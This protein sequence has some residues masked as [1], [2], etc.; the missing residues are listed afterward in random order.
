M[1]PERRLGSV[2]FTDIVGSTERAAVVGDELWRG[3]LQSHHSL[4]RREIGRF[5]G[6]EVSTTGDGFLAIFETPERA[7]RCACA[8]RDAVRQLGIEIRSGVHTGEV[9]RIERTIGG[10]GVHIGARVAAQAGKG[11]VLVSSTTRDLVAGSGFGFEDRGTHALKGVPGEWR[12]FAVTS[13]PVRLPVASFWQR[14]REAGLPRVVFLYLVAGAAIVWA[15]TLARRALELPGWVLP[16]AVLLLVIGLVVLSATAWV[17]AHPF[18]AAR[19]EREEVPGSWEIDLR[20]V[21]RAVASGRL[22]HLTWARAAL[23]GVFA[24]SLLFGL[25]GLYVLLRDR[26]RSLGPPEAVAG[27]GQALAVLPFRVVGTGM[28]LW[29]EGMVDLL[30]T[31]LDGAGGMRTVSPRTLL[32]RWRSEIPEGTEPSDEQALQVARLAGA[33]Y[34]LLGSMVALGGE[35]RLDAKVFDLRSG[36]LAGE[37]QVKGAPDSVPPLVDRLSLEVLRTALAREPSTGERPDLRRLTT[38]S[39][40]ALKAYL[41]GE[42]AFRRSEWERAIGSLA[43]AVEADSTFALALHRLSLA[44]G[45]ITGFS[46]QAVAY[47]ERAGRLIGRLPER[48]S[49]L[50]QGNAEFLEGDAAALVTLRTLTDR[51][52]DDAEA[53]YMLGDAYFHQGVSRLVPLARAYEAFRRSLE[54]DPRFNP[55]Y[56]HLIWDA[57]ERSDS[58]QARELIERYRA[59]G[60]SSLEARASDLAYRVVWGDAASRENAL[61]E[62]RSLTDDEMLGAMPF[63]SWAPDIAGPALRLYQAAM[64]ARG[65]PAVSDA[66]R[67]D[68]I[69]VMLNGGKVREARELLREALPTR[70]LRGLLGDGRPVERFLILAD[71][72]GY[73]DPGSTARAARALVA[74]PTPQDRFL[75]GTLAAREGRAED[76]RRE[77]DALESLAGEAAAAEKAGPLDP[78]GLAQALRAY[79]ALARGDSAEALRELA[80]AVPRISGVCPGDGCWLH[81]MLRYDLG[82]WLLASGRAQEAIPYLQSVSRFQFLQTRAEL[83]LGRAYEETGEIGEARL[84][85]RRFLRWW[86]ESDPELRPLLDEGR[87][88]LQRLTGMV[89]G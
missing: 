30:S 32:S 66:G 20:D 6:R 3:L 35:V 75:V 22:P 54:L 78:A 51:F 45:W 31:N 52:P 15:T 67:W 55:A 86:K 82:R 36:K 27:P 74:E 68:T 14:A 72:S 12:L 69:R 37:T 89:R 57:F 84:S 48:D 29:R 83:Q 19:A 80:A 38:T 50:L 40:P 28:E 8:I 11:E 5:G 85:Y 81:A 73:P 63:M 39:L 59:L 16:L 23:G 53:W 21:G 61:A 71:L 24:F 42:Q 64:Q 2:L 1:K 4:A 44:H 65:S 10:L 49:L 25:A 77:L 17:Q 58:A 46:P 87:A 34:A 60:P 41:E 43:R 70:L 9:E 33:K 18:T 62:V 76:L 13:A 26:G 56:I 47:G 7:I 88:G 79:A